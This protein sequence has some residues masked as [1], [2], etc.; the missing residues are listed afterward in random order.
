MQAAVEQLKKLLSIEDKDI[1]VPPNPEMGD[2]STN[3]AF[4][5]SKE[6]KEN[7]N[8]TAINLMSTIDL[9]KTIFLKAKAFGPYINFFIDYEKLAKKTIK[10]ALIKNYGLLKKSNKNVLIE[11][12]NQNTNKPFH[13]GHL[14]QILL[15]TSL[16]RII[17]SQGFNVKRLNVYNDRG[18]HICQSMVA[19]KKWGKG[20]KPNKKP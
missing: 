4:K 20:K 10:E 17:E 18:I 12:P 9:S 1:S 13:L 7:P 14:L 11:F 3:I 15:G 8:I 16:S 19:Y 2:L 6:K 5:L